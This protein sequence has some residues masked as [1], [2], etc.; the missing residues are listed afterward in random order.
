MKYKVIIEN[1][2]ILEIYYEE[3]FFISNTSVRKT[4]LAVRKVRDI[5]SR[6]YDKVWKPYVIN[7]SV[8]P[9]KAYTKTKYYEQANYNYNEISVE[10]IPIFY[11]RKPLEGK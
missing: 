3:K 2:E 10:G 4:P 6:E 8:Y 1:T 5:S 11:P 7:W 9:R